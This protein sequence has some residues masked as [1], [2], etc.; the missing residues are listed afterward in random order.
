MKGITG[1]QQAADM[2]LRREATPQDAH[3]FLSDVFTQTEH[4]LDSYGS[5]M[6]LAEGIASGQG[7]SH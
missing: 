2:V 6:T 4:H 7:R 1:M 5:L 3:S